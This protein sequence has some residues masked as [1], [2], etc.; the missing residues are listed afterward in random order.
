MVL[1]TRARLKRDVGD[2]VSWDVNSIA[3]NELLLIS[4]SV[5]ACRARTFKSSWTCISSSINGGR[6]TL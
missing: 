2:K 6:R 5:G 4:L 3:R 1:F